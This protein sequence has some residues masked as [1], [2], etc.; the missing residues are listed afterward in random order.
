MNVTTPPKKR[1][2]DIQPLPLSGL[3]SVCLGLG[4]ALGSGQD[5]RG[6]NR[7]P[8]SCVNPA[9]PEGGQ[10]RAAPCAASG[11]HYPSLMFFQNDLEASFSTLLLL[12]C[13]HPLFQPLACAGCSRL[14]SEGEPVGGGL[15][16][17]NEF[18]RSPQRAGVCPLPI[19]VTW[20]VKVSSHLPHMTFGV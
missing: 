9:S 20:G 15:P 14:A 19:H 16:K 6:P 4:V 3:Q 10:P 1:I 5:E 12:L 2:P 11:S 17:N 18:C 13:K 7:A 8:C